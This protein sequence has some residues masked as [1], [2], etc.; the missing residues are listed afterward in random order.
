[1]LRKAGSVVSMKSG[2]KFLGIYLKLLYRVRLHDIINNIRT[3]AGLDSDSVLL[4]SVGIHATEAER[5]PLTGRRVS[6]ET[7]LPPNLWKGV[8]EKLRCTDPGWCTFNFF[9]EGAGFET[10]R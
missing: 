7:R 4:M 10:G 5:R 6:G 1:M 9:K 3:T 8:A 2:S